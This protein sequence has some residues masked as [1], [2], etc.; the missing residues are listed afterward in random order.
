MPTHTT[1]FI[2]P[3]D[4]EFGPVI[5]ANPDPPCKWQARETRRKA[6]CLRGRTRTPPDVKDDAAVVVVVPDP[7][8]LKRRGVSP[9]PSDVEDIALAKVSKRKV[10]QQQAKSSS[11]V[12][13]SKYPDSKIGPQWKSWAPLNILELFSGTGSVGNTFKEAG[14]FVASVDISSRA[15][16]PTHVA[17]I[18]TWD[19][20][21]YSPGT[22]SFIWAS[23]PC[24]HYS[25]ARTTA[26]TPRDFEYYDS[27]VAKTKEIIDWYSPDVWV[28]ENPGTGLLK[29]RAVVKDI[30]FCDVDYCTYGTLYQ[31]RTRLWGSF[32]YLWEPRPLCK[33]DCHSCRKHKAGRHLLVAQRDNCSLDQLHT[34][35]AELIRELVEAM[36]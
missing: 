30:P 16:T 31:K 3:S 10:Q 28:I 20:K 12:S 26:K 14:H 36:G 24:E 23:P 9:L 7:K 18:L 13:A 33:H 19:Y 35:P 17:D 21:Q 15:S 5:A 4:D 29:S 25:R 22:F 6:S 34:V 2:V 1:S 27:L 11:S 8:Q 32:P